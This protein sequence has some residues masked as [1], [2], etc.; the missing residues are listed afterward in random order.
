MFCYK[1]TSTLY[2]DGDNIEN[3]N[4]SVFNGACYYK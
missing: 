3:D 4:K 1:K 2:N